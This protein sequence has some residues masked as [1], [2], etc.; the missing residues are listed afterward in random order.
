MTHIALRHWTGIPVLQGRTS[1]RTIGWIALAVCILSAS[2]YNAFAKILT[3]ALSPLSLFFLSELLTGLFV[4]FSYGLMPVVRSIAKLPRRAILA[5]LAI[6]L[7]NGTIAP[8]LLFPGL[9]MSSAVN[10]SLF[11]N[12]EMVFLIVLAV[13]VLHEPF[14]REHALSICTM[15]A[16]V[17]I[18]ALRGFTEGLHFQAGDA[19]L[20]LSSLSFATGSA[21]FRKF[22]HRT[23]PQLILFMRAAV[24]I[25]CFFLISPF[26]RHPLIEEIQAFPLTLLP[27]LLGFAFIS[28][29]LNI[30]TFYESLDRLP[31]TIVSL[32]Y[33][34]TVITSILFAWWMLREPIMGYHVVGGLFIILGTILLEVAGV[35]PSPQHLARHLR[36]R[37]AHR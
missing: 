13:A 15:I 22:L 29:F 7:T 26:L 21:I 25:S 3:G 32:F 1:S 33:N 5:L 9:R 28:R 14:R 11:G 27:V 35:H 30:F 2:T 4:I 16:G 18:I 8:L 20:I 34:L 17:L 36:Q 6:G 23:E 12:M 24:A 31:V 37:S 19:L 10:A